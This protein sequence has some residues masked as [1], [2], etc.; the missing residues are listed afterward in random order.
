MLPQVEALGIGLR[1]RHWGRVG[2]VF[3]VLWKEGN[4]GCARADHAARARTSR[5]MAW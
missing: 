2:I 4:P 5:H 3:A 1:S